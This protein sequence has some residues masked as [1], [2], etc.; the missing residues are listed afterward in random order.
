MK[1]LKE[2]VSKVFDADLM[3]KTRKRNNVE[4]RMVFSK[5]ARES[6][7]TCVSIGKEINKDHSTVVYYISHIENL[8]N[9]VPRLKSKYLTC[10][11]VFLTNIDYIPTEEK[12]EE[13]NELKL[14]IET[15]MN[16]RAEII[17]VQEKYK[18]IENI[19]NLVAEKT[20]YGNEYAVE[21]KIINLFNNM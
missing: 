20:S 15:L 3:T 7:N 11:E 16:E 6:K 14:L 5:I 8:I 4:A 18:R 19:I 10:K 1:R 17:K 21:R 13:F 9:Q 2:I 12:K